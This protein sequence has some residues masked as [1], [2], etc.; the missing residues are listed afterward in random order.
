VAGLPRQIRRWW[1]SR[2]AALR[3]IVQLDRVAGL[4]HWS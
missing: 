4:L 1:R 2:P 3:L